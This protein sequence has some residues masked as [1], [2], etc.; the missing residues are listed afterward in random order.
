MT[1]NRRISL[2]KLRRGNAAK[3]VPVTASPAV[4][5]LLNITYKQHGYI[6][7]LRDGIP[8]QR[9]K[10]LPLHQR[11]ILELVNH[12]LLE[13][14]THLLVYKWRI[15]RVADKLGNKMLCLCKQHSIL[16]AAYVCNLPVEVVKQGKAA[17]VLVE[18]HYA[19]AK[20]CR[21]AVLLTYLR[22]RRLQ[23]S[24]KGKQICFRFA[25]LGKPICWHIVTVT[26]KGHSWRWRLVVKLGN[27]LK[28]LCE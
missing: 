21:I 19:V 9:Q 14:V 22:N 3:D 6:L 16:L 28:V 7:T 10:V 2:S 23:L 1:D 26:S 20:V 4:D 27:L 15:L 18:Q 11:G 17:V 5:R 13:V 8:K 12:K 24:C 25:L